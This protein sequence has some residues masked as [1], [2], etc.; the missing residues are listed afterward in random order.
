MFEPSYILV[1]T[2]ILRLYKVM[3][4]SD[5]LSWLWCCDTKSKTLSVCQIK[6][7]YI[8]VHYMHSLY[9][10][11]IAKIHIHGKHLTQSIHGEIIHIVYSF[12]VIEKFRN[13]RHELCLYMYCH[14]LKGF[15]LPIWVKKKVGFFISSYQFHLTIE[16]ILVSN[17]N[18]KE[19]S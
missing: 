10:I 15:S 16:P 7:S 2:Y 17:L 13:P 19:G 6:Y 14:L 12:T 9:F 5:W 1:F 3:L 4:S 11:L 18:L 8:L